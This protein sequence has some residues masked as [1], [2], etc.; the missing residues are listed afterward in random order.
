MA[1]DLEEFPDRSDDWKSEH[2][3]AMVEAMVDEGLATWEELGSL[4]LGALNPPQVGTA[5]ASNKSFQRHFP[6]RECWKGVRA[7]LYDQDGHCADCPT[8]LTLQADHI[9]PRKTAQEVGEQLASRDEVSLVHVELLIL[10]AMKKTPRLGTP[11]PDVLTIVATDLRGRILAGE[12]DLAGA[13]DH[14]ENL[15]LRCRRCNVVRRP[16]H[17][18]GG[19]THLTTQAA[20]MWILL[21]RQP[22]TYQDRSSTTCAGPM[23]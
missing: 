2:W 15:A 6:K 10:N 17:K 14:V 19:V 20:V 23:A 4:L 22:A 11:D 7:W 9:I 12:K 1:I 21:S 8:L 3:R 18:H 16:S 13:A 5:Q